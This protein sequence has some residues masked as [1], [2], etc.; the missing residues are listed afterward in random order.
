MTQT[1]QLPTGTESGRLLTV[2]IVED[3]ENDAM[4]LELELERAGYRPTC[5][6]VE[7]AKP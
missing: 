4:L 7:T 1:Q 6:R 5:H 2:L 3:S